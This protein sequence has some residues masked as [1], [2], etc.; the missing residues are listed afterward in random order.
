VLGSACGSPEARLAQLQDTLKCGTSCGSCLPALR[1][2]VRDSVV[3]AA[4]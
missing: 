1:T 2:M 3:T 4:A